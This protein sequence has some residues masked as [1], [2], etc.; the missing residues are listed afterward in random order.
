MNITEWI[1]YYKIKNLI[2]NLIYEP[3]LSVVYS[4]RSFV[5]KGKSYHCPICE[6]DFKKFVGSIFNGACPLCGGGSRQRLLYLYLK[7]KTNFYRDRLKVLHFAPEH[8]FAKKFRSLPNLEYTS[9]D[10]DSPR[11]MEV[12]D[13]TNIQ[14]SDSYFD[15]VLSSHVLEH[16]DDDLLAMRELYRVLKPGGWSIHQVPIDYSI[17]C[18]YEDKTVNT[19]VLRRRFYGHFDH[20]RLYGRDYKKKLESA[21]FVVNED[22]FGDE[23]SKAEI[24]LHGIDS[25]EIIYVCRK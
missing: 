6:C 11:A 16:I 14:Y 9:A 15:V 19:P 3:A 5:Y 21:N 13:M 22:P 1:Y 4:V 18:T 12:V 10:L 24:T 20:K 23:L 7:R 25:S 17:E 2:P 8:C